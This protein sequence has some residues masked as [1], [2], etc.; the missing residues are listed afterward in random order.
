MNL[1]PS[2]RYND[3]NCSYLMKQRITLIEGAADFY[4]QI[5]LPETS[6]SGL[7]E[8]LSRMMLCEDYHHQ[9]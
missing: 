6:Y 5:Q 7:V 1:N 9:E 4:Q 3:T 8:Y 2:G